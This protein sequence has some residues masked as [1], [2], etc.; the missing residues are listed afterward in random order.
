MTEGPSMIDVD[1]GDAKPLRTLPNNS[2]ARLTIIKVS[3][4]DHKKRANVSNLHLWLD[5]GEADVDDVQVWLPIPNYT[6]KADDMKSYTKAVNRFKGF[7]QAFSFT[8]PISDDR[9]IGLSGWA[10]ISEEED[11]MNPGRFR[12]SVRDFI[13]K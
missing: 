8:P 2:E 6:W 9:L 3:I 10:I 5:C 4:E 1:L 11:D 12:N 7:C 13:S